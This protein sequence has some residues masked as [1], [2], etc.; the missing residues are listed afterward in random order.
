M[1]EKDASGFSNKSKIKTQPTKHS[2]IKSKVKQSKIKNLNKPFLPK[3]PK[4]LPLMNPQLPLMNSPEKNEVFV[5][6]LQMKSFKHFRSKNKK[7]V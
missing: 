4:Y 6:P 3:N 5:L 2:Q 7:K 1:N